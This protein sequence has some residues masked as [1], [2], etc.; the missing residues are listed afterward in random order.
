MSVSENSFTTKCMT[1]FILQQMWSDS[2]L[3]FC[4]YV[5]FSATTR[6]QRFRF[7]RKYRQLQITTV[8]WN[9]YVYDTFD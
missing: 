2:N 7:S 5:A 4:G 8:L 1:D 6:N 9:R 3:E